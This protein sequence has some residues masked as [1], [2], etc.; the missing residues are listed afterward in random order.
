MDIIGKVVIG[1]IMVFVLVGAIAAIRDSEKGLGKEFTEGLRSIGPIFIPVA[2]IMASIPYLS[3]FIEWA[4]GPLFG[5]LGADPA[6]A[7]TTFIAVDMGGYQLALSTA[8]DT[9]N[10]IMAA[11]TG[12][13]AGAT[14][15]FSIPVGLAMLQARDHK[16]M[17]LGVM[18]GILTV[19]I[20]VFITTAI[21][22]IS[23]TALRDNVSTTAPSEYV[24]S[25]QWGTILLNLVPLVI[26]VVLIA[27]GLKFVPRLMVSG[28]IWMGRVLDAL[29]KIVLALSIIEYFTGAFS[30]VLGSWGFDPIIA[31][32]DDQFRALEI[33]GYIGIMLAGA[34]PMVY[35]IRT[36]AAKPL[37]KVSKLVGISPEGS[38]G[39]LAAV[40]NVLA[41]F[42]LVKSIPPKDKVLCISFAV[43][44][45]FLFGD[46]LAF[47]A[48]FQP[49]MILALLV[50]K[51]TA[52]LLG[53]AL[54]AWIAVPTARRLEAQD[55]ADGVIAEQE[56]VPADR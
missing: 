53:I 19:P 39:I 31:D 40:A 38:A 50:G 23:G 24:F 12:Y 1:I 42:H 37:G 29:L 3:R 43:C 30:Q 26:V 56:Y 47:T 27:L 44:A 4:V 5:V 2:G 8:G 45:A 46:H 48:N 9:G 6:M 13:M 35:A 41:L 18:S 11:V 20:G 49:N 32:A 34:F 33:A 16:Y 52:G 22:A 36:Y 25:L 17:A 54:A 55:R 51:L 10:W 15:V 14:I 28:F 21:L 7:A